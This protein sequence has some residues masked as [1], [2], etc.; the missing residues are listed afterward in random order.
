MTLIVSGTNGAQIL[1]K[2]L[3]LCAGWIF[4][5]TCTNAINFFL[6]NGIL[7]VTTNI[8]AFCQ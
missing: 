4:F 7:F 2:L 5:V 3:S 8:R 6:V 1:C